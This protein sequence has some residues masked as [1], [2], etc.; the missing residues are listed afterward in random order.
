VP[1]R[2]VSN[3]KKRKMR[4]ITIPVSLLNIDDILSDVDKLKEI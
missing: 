2:K 1:G 4:N 3:F